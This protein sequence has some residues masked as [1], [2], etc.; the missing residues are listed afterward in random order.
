M[1]NMNSPSDVISYIQFLENKYCPYSWRFCEIEIWPLLRI[2]I[3]HK[4]SLEVLKSDHQ[5]NSSTKIG[6]LNSILKTFE[7]SKIKK[8]TDF[9]FLSDNTS[10]LKIN[11]VTIDKLCDPLIEIVSSNNCTWQKWIYTKSP[12]VKLFFQS[13]CVGFPIFI[14]KITSLF[15]KKRK[16]LIRRELENTRLFELLDEINRDFNNRFNINSSNVINLLN[17]FLESVN[18]FY[19]CFYKIK[20]KF[21]FIIDYYNLNNIALI[22]AANKLKIRTADIQHGVQSVLHAGYSGWN[23]E[24]GKTYESLPK[25]F[26]V[27]SNYEK[28]LIES[29]GKGNNNAIVTGNLIRYLYSKPEVIKHEIHTSAIKNI[30]NKRSKGNLNVLFTMQYGIVYENHLFQMIKESQDKFNWFIRLHPVDNNQKGLEKMISLCDKYNLESIDFK[31]ASSIPLEL[32]LLDM[33]IHITHSSSVVL[34]AH[35]FGIKSILFHNYGKL[36]FEERLEEGFLFFSDDYRDIPNLILRESV[37]AKDSLTGSF[38]ESISN[39][40]AF[41]YE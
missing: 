27:W 40:I 29:W 25:Y 9:I 22:I 6:R 2:E 19:K 34:D 3:Y 5:F 11:D 28:E 13:R 20:P 10:Y 18:W 1:S 23:N 31:I 4:L 16:S 8:E 35:S 14:A 15:K 39:K 30:I 24:F 12:N 21:I 17:S 41:I 38:E 33:N 37:R 36:F 26:F 32:L 7:F